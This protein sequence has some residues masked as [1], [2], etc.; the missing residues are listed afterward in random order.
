MFVLLT[1]LDG[2]L[3]HALPV[4]GQSQTMIGGIVAGLVL[5]LLGVL[6]LSRPLG[7]VLRRR[8]R[9]MPVG[10]A[11]NYAGTGAVLLVSVLCL[12]AG[13]AHRPTIQAERRMLQD[14]VVRAVAFIGTRAPP[15]FRENLMHT[16]TY[17][18]QDGVYRTCAPN[19]TDTH[20]YCVIVRP[21]LPAATS[22]VFGGYEPNSVFSEG[23]N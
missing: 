17:T 16:D 22:V 3:L 12:L 1:I 11:R 9:D 20:T 5:N 15:A 4:V 6:F 14:A 21:R 7:A 2:V 8:R 23:T 13:L 19:R 10:V 18:I